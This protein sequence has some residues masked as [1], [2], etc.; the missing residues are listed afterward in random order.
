MTMP[1]FEPAAWLYFHSRQTPELDLC[2]E[3]PLC[4]KSFDTDVTWK[5]S[6]HTSDQLAEAYEAGKREQA[7][8]IE[9]LHSALCEIAGSKSLTATPTQ[10]YQHLQRV[11]SDAT[12][13]PPDNQALEQFAARVRDQCFD[14][15]DP[16]KYPNECDK[17]MVY[18]CKLAIRA[19]KEIP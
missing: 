17:S 2:F 11:A 16:D 6:L 9:R 8:Q 10:F 3:Q 7:A 12:I 14:A 19:I 4:V 18:H 13:T 5:K 15:L 1:K